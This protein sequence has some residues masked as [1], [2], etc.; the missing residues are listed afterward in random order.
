MVGSAL[1][2]RL[3]RE[4]CTVVTVP[5]ADLDLRDQRAVAAFMDRVPAPTS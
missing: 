1:L 2:R 4:R 3:E 5:R